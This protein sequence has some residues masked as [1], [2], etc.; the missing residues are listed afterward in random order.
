MVQYK[1]WQDEYLHFKGI[2]TTTRTTPSSSVKDFLRFCKE[3]KIKL[4]PN[5]LDIGSGPGRNTVYLAKL[6][7]NVTAVDFADAA[8]NQLSGKI[9]QLNLT[10]VKVVK[11]DIARSLPFEDNQFDWALDVVTTV[12]LNDKELRRFERELR[13]VI[14]PGGLFL[15]YVHSRSDQY[16]R[17]RID[18]DGFYTVPSSGLVERAFSRTQLLSVYSRW[19]SLFITEKTFKDSFYSKTY[20]RSLWWAVF[21]KKVH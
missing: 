15:T 2:P 14:K 5:V 16:L 6:G 13:R 7:F 19:E 20:Y 12:S 10:N 4:G 21:R 9:E 17:D 11:V 18:K 3:L 8:L 1:A